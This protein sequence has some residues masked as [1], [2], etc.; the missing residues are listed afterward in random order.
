MPVAIVDVMH[1]FYCGPRSAAS[2]D[3]EAAG[4][5]WSSVSRC[6]VTAATVLAVCEAVG[7]GEESLRPPNPM[8]AMEWDA[9]ARAQTLAGKL[10][11]RAG[12]VGVSG[13][14]SSQCAGS[15]VNSQA[16]EGGGGKV[17]GVER[18][19]AILEAVVSCERVD[20]PTVG[21]LRIGM[22]CWLGCEVAA[23]ADHHRAGQES[24]LPKGDLP[25]ELFARVL[26]GK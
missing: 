5:F 24:F 9:D 14:S 10:Q 18:G 26:L 4:A 25:T 15:R 22:G 23:A 17:G 20:A 6:V 21:A 7:T 3:S 13:R 16:V 19:L 8:V 11:S 2:D 12:G 1:A